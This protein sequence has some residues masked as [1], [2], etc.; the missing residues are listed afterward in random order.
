M[1]T[2]QPIRDAALAWAMATRAP[3]FAD[4]DGF[5]AWL[6]AD[7]AHAAA[8][9]AVQYALEEAD[10]VL[11]AFP[12]PE[13]APEPANDNP[14]GW[15]AGRRGWLG[16]AIAASLV[17]ALTSVMW[18][19]PG[20][21]TLYRTT[22]GK[23]RVIA[24]ADGSTV[25][26]GGGSTLALEGERAARLEGGQALFTIRHDEAN[27]F[28]LT[29]GGERLVDAGTVFD[30][31]L[32][33]ETLDVAVAEGAVIVDPKGQAIRLDPGERA[34]REG[35]RFRLADVDS[36][37]VGEWRRGRISFDGASLAEIAAELTRATGT[38]F[39]SADT[40]TRLSG[41]IA[42]DAVRADPEALEPLL[43]VRITR[44]DDGWMI[45]AR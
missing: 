12:E 26:L 6:E 14:S 37:A 10:A 1:T 34:V 43:G 3:D 28:V 35:G 13:A 42:M 17:V 36:E 19:A 4:W 33:G 24:L 40:A 27:P 31:R 44:S 16:G 32:A 9:D 30:V 45:A 5:A 15:L 20:G 23:T 39:T 8:Y 38:R 29:A 41:S 11:A 22:P 18:F 25:E 21:E 7:S 2:D